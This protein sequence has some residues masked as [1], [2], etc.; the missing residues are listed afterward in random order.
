MQLHLSPRGSDPGDEHRAIKYRPDIDGLRALAVISVVAYHCAPRWVK[1]GYIGVDVFFVISGYLIGKLVYKEICADSFSIAEFYKRRTKRILPALFGVLL[2]CYVVALLMLSPLELARFAREAL[3]AIASCSNFY[4]WRSVDYFHPVSGLNPLLMTWSLGVEEQFYLIFPLLML[5]MRG[6]HWRIQC[7][8]I[9]IPAGLSLFGFLWGSIYHPGFTFYL[10]PTRAWELA[11]GVMLAIYEANRSRSKISLPPVAMD[12]LSLLGFGLVLLATTSVIAGAGCR[13][14]AVAGGFLLIASR[15]R[16]A[17]RVLSWRPIV[18]VGLVSYSWYL[19]HWPMLSFAR[20]ASGAE[21]STLTGLWIGLVSFCCA[22]LSYLLV[23]RP[24][25]ASTTPTSQLLLRYGALAALMMVP[26]AAFRLTR[27]LPQ[28]NPE[29]QQLESVGDQLSSDNCLRVEEY[30]DLP[31]AAPCVPSG[32]GRAIALIGDSHASMIASALR[33][34]AEQAGYRLVELAMSGCPPMSGVSSSSASI[35]PQFARICLKFQ[36]D[37]LRYIKGD[38]SIQAVIVAGYW[39][40]VFQD[41]DG[42]GYV[43]GSDVSKPTNREQS[44]ALAQVGLNRLVSQLEESGKSVYLVQDAPSYSFD[45]SQIILTEDMRLRREIAR[46][47]ASPILRYSAGIAPDLDSR[48]S[49][50]LVSRVAAAHPKVRLIDLRSSLCTSS[51]CE[52]AQGKQTLYIDTDHLSPLGAQ[53]ALAGLH[54]Q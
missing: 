37:T 14:L 34:I 49:R 25:R 4:F 21:I 22:V 44:W 11:S 3:S 23:E 30:P 33:P 31:L 5:L 24:F 40:G 53:I 46:W 1:S 51:S 35:G 50:G 38:K 52:F 7:C 15:D 48:E 20:I 42:A 28:R 9:G 43:D 27:G 41:S 26:P 32:Q 6:K 13:L 36:D 17:N 10:L 29:V 47:M 18:F 16:I 19:W 2:F 12:G 8:A 45:P 39:A 54:L